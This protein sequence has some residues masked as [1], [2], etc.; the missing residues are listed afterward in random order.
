[1][2]A[3]VIKHSRPRVLPGVSVRVVT[4]CGN[5]YVHLNWHEGKLFEIFA[6]LGHSGG[7]AASQSEALTRAVTLGLRC[8]VDSAEYVKNLI[9]IQ[10]PSPIMFPMESRVLSCSDA[11]GKAVRE[12]HSWGTSELVAF[13]GRDNIVERS[14]E[15]IKVV[16]EKQARDFEERL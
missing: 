2:V 11:V 9:E 12:F 13:I 10:C 15:E 6:T 5:M 4:G 7:C 8:G 1:M 14:E 16:L 3:Q